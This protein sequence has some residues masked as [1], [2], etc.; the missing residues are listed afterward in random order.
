MKPIVYKTEKD[1]TDEITQRFWD[2]KVTENSPYFTEE[3][4]LGII[5][6][7]KEKI[8]LKGNILDYG[9]GNGTFMSYLSKDNSANKIHGLEFSF[10]SVKKS[11]EMNKNNKNIEAIIH[12]TELDKTFKDNYFD[13]VFL[14]ETIEHLRSD[15][16]DNTLKIINRLLKPGGHLIVTTPFDEDLKANSI[17]CPF[18]D[19]AHH[20]M[21]H[22]QSFTKERLAQVLKDH[23]FIVKEVNNTDFLYY[24][25][26]FGY[27]KIHTKWW[28]KHKLGVSK[29]LP[30]QK[31]HLFGI[32]TKA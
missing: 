20:H 27:Y 23:S 10:D 29:R 5:K 24:Q 14:I 32:A 28:L 7:I 30:F 13:V 19:A 4:G 12:F 2:Y 17:Y 3:A 6:M 9:C 22:V 1:W 21:Q 11:I 8:D 26:K 18:C 31:K 15:L 16:L 25:D